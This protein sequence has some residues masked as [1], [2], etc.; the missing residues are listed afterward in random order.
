[1]IELK[2]ENKLSLLQLS[3]AI[4]IFYLNGHRMG[5]TGLWDI[6]GSEGYIYAAF[7]NHSPEGISGDRKRHYHWIWQ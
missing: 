3:D 5:S 2:Q 6:K 4:F 1:L 7:K